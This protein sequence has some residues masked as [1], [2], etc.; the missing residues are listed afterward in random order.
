[1]TWTPVIVFAV[2]FCGTVI[3]VAL[4]SRRRTVS[5]RMTG[6]RGTLLVAFV[7]LV[8]APISP[9]WLFAF[10]DPTLPVAAPGGPG[11]CG[12]DGHTL[13]QLANVVVIV[14]VPLLRG[15]PLLIAAVAA[16]LLRR[17]KRLPSGRLVCT[18]TS[19]A[20]G[21]T[22][23][24]VGG[25][26]VL[27]GAPPEQFSTY[28]AVTPPGARGWRA[29]LVIDRLRTSELRALRNAGPATLSEYVSSSRASTNHMAPQLGGRTLA[30]DGL[31]IYV[32][33]V[34]Y[35]VKTRTRGD[36]QL[37]SLAD[38]DEKTFPPE[39]RPH[40]ETIPEVASTM[41]G[42]LLRE[43]RSD[44]TVFAVVFQANG[45]ARPASIHEVSWLVRPSWLPFLACLLACILLLYWIRGRE[46]ASLPAEQLARLR[47][48]AAWAQL[49]L[50]T[51][52]CAL[53]LPYL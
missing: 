14:G 8:I 22:L 12:D 48:Y 49:E 4:E 19:V 46:R 43:Q 20:L 10:L 1:M 32:R 39:R 30:H 51:L 2:L 31:K 34:A 33:D 16:R 42:W 15:V 6:P 11:G 27:G 9:A 23:F 24:V 21:V 28:G 40:F 38:P 50:A 7:M 17:P 5:P 18:G 26:L 52:L 35:F 3:L 13:G 53:Y 29:R 41:D 44:G 45:N 47:V 36:P 25:R 37:F